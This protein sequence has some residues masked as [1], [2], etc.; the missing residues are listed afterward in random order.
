MRTATDSCSDSEAVVAEILEMLRKYTNSLGDGW[1][2]DTTMA[3]AQVDSFDLVELV[4]NAEEKYGIEIAF[5][6]NATISPETT[7][8]E[9]ARLVSQAIETAK[10]RA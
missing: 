5:N 9:V 4:F 2:K 6:S 10:Q 8:G 7:V 1:T 3:E